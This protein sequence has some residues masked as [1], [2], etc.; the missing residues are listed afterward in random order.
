VTG[1][2][3]LDALPVWTLAAVIIGGSVLFSV[4]LQ[5]LVR[6]RLGVEFIASNH[7]VAGFKYAVV[8]VAYAV[9]LA[10]VVVGVWEQ[11]EDTDNA[12]QAEAE[13]FYNL[14]RHSYN[15]A[16][17]AGEKIRSTLMDYAMAVRDDDWPEMEKGHRGSEKAA[18]AYAKLSY[19]VGQTKSPDIAMLPTVLHGIDLMKEMADFRLERLSDVGGHMTP[20]IWGVLILGGL[21]TLAYPA[22]FATHKVAPQVLM[23]AGLAM[24]VG[25]IFFLTINLNFPFTGPAHIKP[26]AIDAVIQRMKTEE[27]LHRV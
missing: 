16:P 23:T 11:H 4:G 25:A 24:I 2:E 5:L 12:A 3:L 14:F 18:A 27:P 10:F 22:F 1:L 26:E 17:D 15:Y 7:E 21:I 20:V 9:L 13:R 19:I 6:W 8:G